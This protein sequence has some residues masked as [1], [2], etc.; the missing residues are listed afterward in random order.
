M[1]ELDEILSAESNFAGNGYNEGFKE[2]CNIGWREGLVIGLNQ[3][4]ENGLEIGFYEGFITT[5]L[6]LN[7][8]ALANRSSRIKSILRRMQEL[9]SSFKSTSDSESSTIMLSA[10]R[11]NFK[12]LCSLLKLDQKV[13][14]RSESTF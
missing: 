12:Q 7:V 8:E 2:G 3:G 6:N 5:T 10:C 13:I 11:D 4:V 9:I 14:P 1:D